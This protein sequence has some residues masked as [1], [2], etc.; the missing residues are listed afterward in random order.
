[1]EG[2]RINAY[3]TEGTRINAYHTE[4]TRINAYHTEGSVDQCLSHLPKVL[5][6]MLITRKVL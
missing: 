1:M 6:S 5:G 3:H 2:S 4:G